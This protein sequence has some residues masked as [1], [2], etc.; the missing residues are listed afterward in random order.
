ML[1]NNAYSFPLP[2][3]KKIITESK[4][5]LDGFDKK[6]IEYIHR[7]PIWRYSLAHTFPQEHAIDIAVP[8][9]T[10]VTAALSDTIVS[11]NEASIEYG[12]S[13]KYADTVNFITL[14][15]DNGEFSQYLHLDK[16]SI[17]K[18]NLDINN[19]VSKG[20]IIA[21]TGNS[22]FMTHPHLH[23]VIFRASDNEFGYKSIKIN[24]EK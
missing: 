13:M 18:Y 17:S 15:H 23:F 16:E 2:I 10:P 8:L 5:I 21:E 1:I 20:D 22:G 9:Y 4:N 24:F 11:M 7:Y 12:P 3:D 6:L 14:Q 19:D